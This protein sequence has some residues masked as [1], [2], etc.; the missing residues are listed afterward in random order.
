M[1]DLRRDV[2]V[3]GWRRGGAARRKSYPKEAKARQTCVTG[4]N[5]AKQER[6]M[7]SGGFMSL[8]CNYR[9]RKVLDISRIQN[10]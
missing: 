8:T 2:M 6:A 3:M 4:Y 7:V 5:D 9:V 10:R 1:G